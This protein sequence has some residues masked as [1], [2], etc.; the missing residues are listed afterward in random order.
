MLYYIFLFAILITGTTACSPLS[1]GDDTNMLDNIKTLYFTNDNEDGVLIFKQI[2]SYLVK[3]YPRY[4]NKHQVISLRSYD[5]TEGEDVIVVAPGCYEFPINVFLPHPVQIEV[6]ESEPVGLESAVA[7]Y[8]TLRITGTERDLQWLVDRA[9]YA[10]EASEDD[11][12]KV[13]QSTW[14]GTWN[15]GNRMSKFHT[16]QKRKFN[17]VFLDEGQLELIQEDIIKFFNRKN[18]YKQH[19]I[20]YHRNYLLS[21]PPGTGKTSL[22]HAVASEFKLGMSVIN[23]H[24]YFDK[25]SLTQCMASLPKDVI[26]VVEDVDALYDAS[27]SS[28]PDRNGLTFSDFINAIDGFTAKNEGTLLFMTTNHPENIDPA[29]LRPGR[30]DLS[31]ELTYATEFQVRAIW[32][33]YYSESAD[34]FYRLYQEMGLEKRLSAA[35]LQDFFF[36]HIDDSA[37]KVLSPKVM[38]EL[39]QYLPPSPVLSTDTENQSGNVTT[40]A[41]TKVNVVSTEEK[42]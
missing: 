37:D 38:G 33:A 17:T 22:I 5:T 25:T 36:R 8:R 2:S 3:T 30:V 31:M 23:F 39:L 16:I 18:Q 34:Q 21:G 7:V 9:Q 20:P 1:C 35:S 11:V 29:L 10:A 40:D 14:W 12:V 28:D 32:S 13:Y 15:G 26:I 19:G 6:T 42:A 4:I 24:R 27:R 41:T